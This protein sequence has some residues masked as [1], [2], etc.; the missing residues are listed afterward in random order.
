MDKIEVCGVC[1]YNFKNIN[2]IIFCDKLIVITGF[3]GLGKF[4]LVFD[5]LYVE[6]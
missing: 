6:G 2:L 1:I 4:L 5:M 3:F